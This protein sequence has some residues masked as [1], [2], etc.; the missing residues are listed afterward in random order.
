M[1]FIPSTPFS[2]INDFMFSPEENFSTVTVL[3]YMGGHVIATFHFFSF[4]GKT[5]L[6]HPQLFP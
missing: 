4:F 6:P 2:L 1:D 5:E 3:F